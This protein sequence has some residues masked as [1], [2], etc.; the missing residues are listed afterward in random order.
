MKALA[1]VPCFFA[2]V[3]CQ[4]KAQDKAEPDTEA[5]AVAEPEPAKTPLE[6]DLDRICNA[7]EYSGALDLPTG[8]RALHT[9]IWLAKNIETQ[10]IRDFVAELTKLE[11]VPRTDRLQAKLAEYKIAECEI[12]HAWGGGQ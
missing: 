1:L 6:R 7:E 3:A 10:E 11:A 9:G 12:V 2:L 5:L 8:D 4:P